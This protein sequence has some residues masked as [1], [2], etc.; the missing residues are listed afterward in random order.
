[1]YYNYFPTVKKDIDKQDYTNMK[2]A[3]YNAI[4]KS[5]LIKFMRCKIIVDY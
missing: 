4:N 3:V 5:I 1:M 2:N